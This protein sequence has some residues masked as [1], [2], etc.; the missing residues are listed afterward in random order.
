MQARLPLALVEALINK[1][2]G[3]DPEFL[4]DLSS[5]TGTVIAVDISGTGL[6]FLIVL[7]EDRVRILSPQDYDNTTGLTPHVNISGPPFSLLRRLSQLSTGDVPVG[8]ETRISGDVAV[9]QQ[10]RNLFVRLE[11]D[12]EEHL[13]RY[14]GDIAAHQMARGAGSFWRWSR[15]VGETLVQDSVEYLVHEA[16]MLT[17]QR[18]TSGFADAVDNLREDT[19]RMEL[20]VA[21]LLQ[22]RR[23]GNS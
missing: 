22:A 17:T 23:G 13:S 11:I 18:D 20:R 16:H 10:L 9:L 21:R 6:S 3:L 15:N 8:D 19:D 4:T 5:L 1:G 2:A 7:D 12:W 14:V